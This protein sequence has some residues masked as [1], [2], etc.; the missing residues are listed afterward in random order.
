MSYYQ[1]PKASKC[2]DCELQ[3]SYPFCE[4]RIIKG[5]VGNIIK[6]DCKNYIKRRKNEL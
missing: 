1:L 2:N 4:D 6:R 3:P 5:R